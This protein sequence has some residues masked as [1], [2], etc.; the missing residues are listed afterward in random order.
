MDAVFAGD[1]EQTRESDGGDRRTGRKRRAHAAALPLVPREPHRCRLPPHGRRQA[2]RQGRRRPSPSR[3]SL[4]K[5]EPPLPAFAVKPD[6]AYLITGGLG[7]FG[8]VLAEWLVE[9]GARHLV[10][11]SRSGAS[12]PEAV[13]FRGETRKR[14]I[15]VTV[16]KA[17]IGSPE[18][19]KRLLGLAPKSAAAQGD[20][21]PRHGHRRRAALRADRERLRTVM[22]PKAHGAWLLHENTEGPGPRLLRD[23]L[24]RLQHL[25]Q[26]RPRATTRRP[27]PSSIRSPI[28]AARWVFPRWR[29]TGACSAAKVTS[30]ATS[31]SPNSSPA[32]A[33]PP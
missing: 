9:C 26:S 13:A 7:G 3:L 32:R 19:V 11:S 27:T 17:D 23:V 20:L 4:R 10:L 14:G 30:R 6:G 18:D 15:K 12:T 5:G 29:S 25:R 24:L 2:H 8:R 21:P 33:P 22:A 31:V 28:I 16:V 1:E